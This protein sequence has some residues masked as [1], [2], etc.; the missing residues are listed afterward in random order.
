M[1]YVNKTPALRI[2][3]STGNVLVGPQILYQPNA[4]GIYCTAEVEYVP[5]M[6]GPWMN[7][8]YQQRWKLLGYRPRVTLEFPIVMASG[9]S[10]MANLYQYYVAGLTGESF[11]ALEFNL[12]ASTCN[13]WRGMVPTTPWAPKPARGKER[14]GYELSIT[15][16]ARNLI[17]AP[18]DATTGTW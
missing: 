13:V 18:G 2:V 4:Q 14:Q 3:N 7:L 9:Y 11:A 15:L 6:L 16:D 5:E 12:R 1:S 8:A 17:A 10:G